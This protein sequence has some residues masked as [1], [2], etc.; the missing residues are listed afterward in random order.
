M[1]GIACTFVLFGAIASWG[2]GVFLDKTG[3]YVCILRTILVTATIVMG[4]TF[5][6]FPSGTNLLGYAWGFLAGVFI[7]P[8]VPVTYNFI[9]ETTHPLA[10][11]LVLNTTLIVANIVLTLYDVWGVLV[12]SDPS[13]TKQTNAF[14]VLASMAAISVV[15]FLI[16]LFVKEDLRRFGAPDPSITIQTKSV[17]S[18]ENEKFIEAK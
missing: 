12:L 5:L 8:I 15:S 7:V 6:I 11:A 14:I 16:S 4:S 17:S 1:A 18:N 13:R 10:P 9:T 3:K 2:A